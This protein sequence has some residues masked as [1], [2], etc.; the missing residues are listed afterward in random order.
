M[1]IKTWMVLV[2]ILAGGFF[3]VQFYK[4]QQ[5]RQQDRETLQQQLELAKIKVRLLDGVQVRV[6]EAYPYEGFTNIKLEG[7]KKLVAL[8]LSLQGASSDLDCADFSLM[9]GD[10]A[11]NFGSDAD[12]VGLDPES[13]KIL[14]DQEHWPPP[15][16]TRRALLIFDVPSTLKDCR[17]TFWGREV[18]TASVAIKETPPAARPQ[19]RKGE[20]SG[21]ASAFGRRFRFTGE[22]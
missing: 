11:Q 8:D 9:S 2:V 6:N 15:G 19:P 16:K 13:G 10:K 22:K 7:S 1:R 17:L 14:A 21:G 3:A 5:A 20:V 18:T 4:G 12:R